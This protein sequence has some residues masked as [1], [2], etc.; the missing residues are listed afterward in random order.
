MRHILEN[1]QT[2]ALPL[3]ENIPLVGTQGSRG[4][5]AEWPQIHHPD[6]HTLPEL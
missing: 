2:G 5:P 1:K 4:L 6:P 3:S